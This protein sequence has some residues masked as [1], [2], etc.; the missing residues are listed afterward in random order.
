[1]PSRKAAV[2]STARELL[3]LSCGS[4]TSP[5]WPL[6]GSHPD[7]AA[8]K[9]PLL[10]AAPSWLAVLACCALFSTSGASACAP[11][12]GGRAGD[13]GSS[14]MQGLLLCQEAETRGSGRRCRLPPGWMLWRGTLQAVH[15]EIFCNRDTN[16]VG[17]TPVPAAEPPQSP[18]PLHIPSCAAW[19]G[20]AA[21][22]SPSP[23]AKPLPGTE[24]MVQAPLL[25][26][27]GLRA[28]GRAPSCSPRGMG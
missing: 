2:P 9:Q 18:V 25:P 14:W 11:S 12:A 27:R 13:P 15:E 5:W 23:S 16:S 20:R 1:M 4:R 7:P 8:G 21:L 10:G 28:A 26:C 19:A 17:V 3:G 22:G 24:E 6:L